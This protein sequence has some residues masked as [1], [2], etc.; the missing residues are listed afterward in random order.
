MFKKALD[1]VQNREMKSES[2][3]REAMQWLA[4]PF[5]IANELYF[6]GKTR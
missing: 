6:F 5:D 3:F 4:N 2:G 1:N